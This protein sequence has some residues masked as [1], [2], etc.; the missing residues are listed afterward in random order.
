MNEPLFSI[1]IP[2]YNVEAYLEECVDSI[3]NQSLREIEIIH[4]DD[5]STD[6]SSA[7]CDRFGAA[8]GRIKVVHKENGGLSS[9]R[10]TGLE[11]ATGHYIIF[12]DSDDII[13]NE[14]LSEI[15]LNT[16]ENPD[17]I[18]TE[19]LNTDDVASHADDS[20]IMFDFPECTTK[21]QNIRY[22]FQEKEHTWPSVD[23]IVRREFLD[24]IGL[25]FLE[26]YYHEDMAW[27][28]RL[29]A[30]ANIFSYYN[31]CW[32]IRRYNREG[33]ITYTVNSKRT[34]D[35]LDIISSQLHDPY[36]NDLDAE[37]RDV[38][39]KRLVNSLYTSL[40]YCSK[41]KKEDNKLIAEKIDENLKDFMKYTTKLDRRA[42]LL[43]AKVFG[44]RFALRAV[45]P[46]FANRK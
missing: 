44:S 3:R 42:F 18:I 28:A 27:T 20:R 10:N 39:F 32:Y 33:S 46:L 7:I 19:I 12:I 35:V 41:Y 36:Y 11:I 37:S 16:A 31:K 1:I 26:G 45:S 24:R 34:M 30:K 40:T 15:V 43:M 6:N 4:V 38:I 23:Y 29:M 8:D 22:V 17:V 25:N 9:T 13:R 5:G 14:C 2:V 21:E